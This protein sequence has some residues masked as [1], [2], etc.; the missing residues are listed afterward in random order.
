MFRLNFWKNFG[1]LAGYR[2]FVV[3]LLVI[4]I[5]VSFRLQDLIDGAQTVD[6]LKNITLAFIGGNAAEHLTNTA[7]EYLK[8][9]TPKADNPDAGGTND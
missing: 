6:L 2:K 9:K 8:T 3:M 1:T 7:K 5:A 4:T